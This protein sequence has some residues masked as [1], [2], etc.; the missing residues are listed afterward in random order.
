MPAAEEA[1]A[2]YREL[3]RAEAAPDQLAEAS[4]AAYLP[5]L[6]AS[7]SNLGTRLAEAGRREEAL[8]AEEEAVTIYRQLAEASPAAHLP[9]LAISL[10]NLGNRLAEA[11]R[12]DEAE[13]L[14]RDVLGSFEHS[15]LGTGHILLVRGR[16]LLTQHRLSE[17]VT[18]LVAAV[19]AFS[20]A[21]DRR[22]RGQVRQLLRQLRQHDQPAFDAAWDQ[23]RG[24][25]PVWL[26]HPETDGELA[27]AVIAWLRTPD[28]AASRAY[29]DDHAATLLTD[30][31]EAALE[32]LIDRNPCLTRTA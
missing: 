17:A 1:V 11:G 14:L 9:D 29:L 32:H 8:A 5:D 26:Q 24:L 20:Q 16:W 10:T 15:P 30:R 13:R 28:W 4:P 31:A 23:A 21:R 18:D 6:A 2:I 12:A 22:M 25:L 3:V 19:G 27:D 7:L